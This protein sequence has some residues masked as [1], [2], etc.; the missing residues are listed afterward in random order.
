MPTWSIYAVSSTNPTPMN[1]TYMA[2]SATQTDTASATPSPSTV[3]DMDSMSMAS[4]Q[5]SD[6]PQSLAASLVAAVMPALFLLLAF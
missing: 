5:S 6:A 3:S 1:T 2:P 4:N